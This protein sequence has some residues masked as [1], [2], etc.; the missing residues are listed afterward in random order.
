MK[1]LL[2]GRAPDHGELTEVQEP[3]HHSVVELV[4]VARQVVIHPA[5]RKNCYKNIIGENIDC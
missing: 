4:R 5:W 2:E 3:V 1:D